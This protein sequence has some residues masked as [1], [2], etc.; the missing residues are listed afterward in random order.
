MSGRPRL[1][2]P[3][4]PQIGGIGTGLLFAVMAL[5]Q[6]I[7]AGKC[8]LEATDESFGFYRKKF[9]Q[10]EI[11]DLCALAPAEQWH[12]MEKTREAWSRLGLTLQLNLDPKSL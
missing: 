12:Y 10:M 7:S 11:N 1:G 2:R 5:G 6:Q 4:F 9:R 8:L 3:D